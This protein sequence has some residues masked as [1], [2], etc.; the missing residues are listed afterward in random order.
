M[1]RAPEFKDTKVL[2]NFQKPVCLT[3]L[4]SEI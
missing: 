4:W 2:V 3:A 1:Q